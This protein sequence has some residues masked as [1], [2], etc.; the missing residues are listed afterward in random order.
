M[1]HLWDQMRLPRA[2]S[3]RSWK[4]SREKTEQLLCE[5]CSSAWLSSRWKGFSLYPTPHFILH[6]LFLILLLCTVRKSPLSTSSWPLHRY[7]KVAIKPSLLQATEVQFLQPLL[8]E[9]VLHTLNTS[10]GFAPVH[11]CLSYIKCAQNWTQQIS[12]CK[13]KHCASTLLH[14]LVLTA[15]AEAD[16]Y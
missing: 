16:S 14:F 1:G 9:Q 10:A 5:T 3:I 15:H 13:L 4:H 11:H 12:S 6:P 8:S 7:R 2:L